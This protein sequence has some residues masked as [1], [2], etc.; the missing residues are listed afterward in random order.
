MSPPFYVYPA[1]ALLVGTCT[2]VSLGQPA[3]TA[4]HGQPALLELLAS[5]E[6]LC[7]CVALQLG[8][9][10]RDP[11]TGHISLTGRAYIEI[12]REVTHGTVVY[13]AVAGFEPH[14]ARHGWASAVHATDSD[15]RVTVEVDD[16]RAER[17]SRVD[18]TLDMRKRARGATSSGRH[19]FAFAENQPAGSLVPLGA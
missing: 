4:Q 15:G 7:P 13:V 14:D 2:A 1:A 8:A 5:R 11:V 19:P 12:G 18:I 10:F 16:W 6:H 3:D 9:P 17:H